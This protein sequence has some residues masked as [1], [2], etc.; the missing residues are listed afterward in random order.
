MEFAYNRVVHSTTQMSPFEIVYG[1]NH[2]TLLDLLP[3]PDIDSMTNKDEL[4]KANFVKNLHKEVKAQ[5]EKKMEKLASKTNQGRKQIKFEPGD[6]VWVHFRKERFPSKRKSKL[7]PRGDGPFQV[8]KR[9][10]DNDY[11]VNLPEDYGVSSS[12]NINDL[13]PFDVGSKLRTTSI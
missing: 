9:I 13:S 5:I 8:L 3:L 4:A 6:W 1:F 11:V 10:N 2:L 7:L 12:F